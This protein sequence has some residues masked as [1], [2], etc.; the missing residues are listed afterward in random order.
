[1]DQLLLKIW[2]YL[3]GK[4]YK[5]EASFYQSGFWYSLGLI[6]A[7]IGVHYNFIVRTTGK[8]IDDLTKKLDDLCIDNRLNK[9]EIEL[10][11]RALSAN[12]NQHEFDDMIK[13]IVE[14]IHSKN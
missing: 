12:N 10:I 7:I 14:K 6:I 3:Q 5:M 1:M 13:K 11:K 9:G 2:L 4:G 8:K